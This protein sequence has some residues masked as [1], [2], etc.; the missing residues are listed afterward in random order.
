MIRKFS[1]VLCCVVAVFAMLPLSDV[2]AACRPLRS[3]VERQPVRSVLG[4]VIQAQPVRSVLKAV[5]PRNHF[6]SAVVPSSTCSTGTCAT[7]GVAEEVLPAPQAGVAS[8]QVISGSGQAL[9]SAMY[10]AQNNIQ[11]H[12]AYDSPGGVGWATHNPM[13]VTCFGRGGAN[14][15]VVKSQYGYF[16]TKL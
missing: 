13:P 7:Q 15:A 10:R 14:Y 8:V 12:T 9:Q 6:A 3:L 1:S 4:R 11:G 16:A 2:E 5:C